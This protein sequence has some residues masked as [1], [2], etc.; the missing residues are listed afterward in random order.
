MYTCIREQA[1][2]YGFFILNRV[3]P[4][5]FI[6]IINDADELGSDAGLFKY[7]VYGPRYKPKGPIRKLGN[8]NTDSSSSSDEMSLPTPDAPKGQPKQTIG[9]WIHGEE[10]YEALSSVMTRVLMCV[11]EGQAY[12]DEYRYVWIWRFI[13]FR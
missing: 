13:C 12:P 9:L 4:N 2:K 6:Q 11:R 10:A 5:D 7:Y 8:S 3:G 1:P